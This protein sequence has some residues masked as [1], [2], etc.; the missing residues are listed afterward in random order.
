MALCAASHSKAFLFDLLYLSLSPSV[1]SVFP[2]SL[3]LSL[4]SSLSLPLDL[5]LAH[6]TPCQSFS[7]QHM[8]SGILIPQLTYSIYCRFRESL[9]QT[10]C[11]IFTCI[12]VKRRVNREVSASPR[13]P[14]SSQPQLF[15]LFMY[16]DRTALPYFFCLRECVSGL[17]L[18]MKTE[19]LVFSFCICALPLQ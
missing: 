15:K 17:S 8:L 6:T 13:L 11:H 12:V 1:F 18:L 4:H 3:S 16:C 10:C 19:F 5:K 7:T 9:Q 14:P 2:L